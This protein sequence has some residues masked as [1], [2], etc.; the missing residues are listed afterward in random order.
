MRLNDLFKERLKTNCTALPSKGDGV[1]LSRCLA[2][3]DVLKCLAVA[4]QLAQMTHG[5]ELRPII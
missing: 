3:E 1:A 4:S 5:I 2:A